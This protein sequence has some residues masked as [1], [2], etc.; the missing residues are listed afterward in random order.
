MLSHL[1]KQVQESPQP[2]TR[3]QWWHDEPSVSESIAQSPV[4]QTPN[5]WQS[6]RSWKI[7]QHRD[8][9][10]QSG[11]Y[12]FVYQSKDSWKAK[13]L[14]ARNRI[15]R[16]SALAWPRFLQRSLWQSW[17][18]KY[19]WPCWRRNWNLR[20]GFREGQW[21]PSSCSVTKQPIDVKAEFTLQHAPESKAKQAIWHLWQPVSLQDSV[22]WATGKC[23]HHDAWELDQGT[24]GTNKEAA[25]QSPGK[26][27]ATR[28]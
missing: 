15:L 13:E 9:V 22:D 3:T 5:S 11:R 21:H 16:P 20:S 25:L 8:S 4:P 18:W 1:Q 10:K 19:H 17:L 24:W 28:Q 23:Q 12:S 2:V 26:D 14:R 6:G 7:D 27:P